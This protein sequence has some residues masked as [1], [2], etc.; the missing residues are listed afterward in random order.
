LLTDLGR[1]SK[2]KEPQRIPAYTPTKSQRERPQ[3][4]HK[5]ITKKGLRKSPKG[6][7]RKTHPSHEEP[8]QIIYTYQR[9]S[10][11]V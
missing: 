11:K 5:K 6:E 10:Y 3:N 8:R 2:G 1:E 4:C 9:G 7:M